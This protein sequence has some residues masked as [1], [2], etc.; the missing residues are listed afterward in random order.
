M[1]LE[2]SDRLMNRFLMLYTVYKASVRG[3]LPGKVKLLKLL[4]E[5][6]EEMAKAGIRGLTFNFY[7]W[8][9]GPLSNEALSD[10]EYLLANELIYYRQEPWEIGYTSR[11]GVVLK[12]SS[13]LLKQ[14][15]EIVALIDKVVQRHLFQSGTQVRGEI[16]D[17]RIPG[18]KRKVGEAEMGETL[19]KPMERDKARQI[20]RIDED[21]EDTLYLLM[22]KRSMEALKESRDD[23][24]HGRIERHVP[25]SA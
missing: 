18:G 4:Y 21:W 17:H 1:S 16:Y 19:L 11:G 5:A 25:A 2:P 20:A 12:E 13:D 8:D 6:Q 10:F 24:K 23:I 22:N 3:V 15:Q 7:R 9:Y 14:N